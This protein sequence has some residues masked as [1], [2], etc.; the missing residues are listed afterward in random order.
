MRKLSNV[1]S[2]V[3]VFA[4]ARA[5][6]GEPA[7]LAEAGATD[8]AVSLTPAAGPTSPSDGLE[9]QFLPYPGVPAWQ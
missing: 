7:M 3:A 9:R 1:H 5:A 6:T 4:N 8:V 2:A